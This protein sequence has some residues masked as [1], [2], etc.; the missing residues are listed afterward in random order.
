MDTTKH[1]I[2]KLNRITDAWKAQFHPP[3]IEDEDWDQY[4]KIPPDLPLVWT[5]ENGILFLDS[6]WICPVKYICQDKLDEAPEWVNPVAMEIDLIGGSL[7]IIITKWMGEYSIAG[8][9]RSVVSPV[10]M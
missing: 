1:L 3:Y 10:R 4:L 5:V 7:N 9:E 8:V 6:V 2:D